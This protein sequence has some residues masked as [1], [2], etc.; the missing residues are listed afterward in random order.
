MFR[1]AADGRYD[2]KHGAYKPYGYSADWFSLGCMI[3]TMLDGKSPFTSKE[4]RKWGG[5]KTDL[6]RSC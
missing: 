2:P 4:A 5:A 6:R 3:Y 1:R